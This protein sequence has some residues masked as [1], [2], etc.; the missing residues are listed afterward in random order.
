[1]LTPCEIGLPEETASAL[2]ICSWF[3]S[4]AIKNTGV[5]DSQLWMGGIFIII[6]FQVGGDTEQ[7]GALVICA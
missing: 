7:C 4:L 2:N 1:M 3:E 5:W 6:C